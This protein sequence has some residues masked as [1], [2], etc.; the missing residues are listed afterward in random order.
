M[1]LGKHSGRNAFVPG[2]LSWGVDYGSEEELNEGF[3]SFKELADKKAR[4]FR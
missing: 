2:W 3:R 4:N 1:V